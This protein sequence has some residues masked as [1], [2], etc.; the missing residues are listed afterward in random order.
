LVSTVIFIYF[1]TY[2]LLKSLK[3]KEIY[4]CGTVNTSRKVFPNATKM[5]RGQHEWFCS[6]DGVSVVAWKDNNPVLAATNFIDP[7]PVTRVNRKSKDGTIQQITCSELINI[8]NINMNC[9]DHF[10]QLRS[11]Y[12]IDRKSKKWWHCIFF[13]F[14]DA[15]VV[16]AF[17][18]HKQFTETPMKLKDLRH[19]VIAGF[20]A[21]T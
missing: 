5:S 10:D 8:Y 6:S 13:F 20:V 11:L 4:A 21:V 14:L 17:I 19:E 9:V 16:S 7:V 3:E 18:L 1:T 15:A 2:E 12:E